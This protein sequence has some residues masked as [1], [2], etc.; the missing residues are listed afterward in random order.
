[1]ISLKL[2]LPCAGGVEAYLAE[3]VARI[4][5][6]GARELRTARGGVQLTAAWPEM[7]KLN[8]RSRLAQRVLVQ[9]AHTPYRGEDDLYEAAQAVAWEQWFTPRESF[10]IE[11]LETG[12]NFRSKWVAGYIR[13][14]QEVAEVTG[15]SINTVTGLPTNTT[16]GQEQQNMDV[17][18]EVYVRK[19]W[20]L[21]FAGNRDFIQ[22]AWVTRD[23]GVFYHDECIRVDVIYR[24]QDVVIGRLGASNQ[25]ALRLTLATLGGPINL[26]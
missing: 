8:L 19:N 18:G 7:M 25:V 24:R 26:R 6:E 5:G 1:M 3:E 4:C 17:G 2:F 22:N 15:L 11:R 14:F 20:G 13:Y 21:S 23:V 9:L 10:K 12:T 16:A